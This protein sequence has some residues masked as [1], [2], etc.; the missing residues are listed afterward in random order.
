MTLYSAEGRTLPLKEPPSDAFET[1]SGMFSL[2]LVVREHWFQKNRGK[3]LRVEGILQFALCDKARY[4]AVHLRRDRVGVPCVRLCTANARSF[5]C[6]S[7]F[8]PWTSYVEAD[9]TARSTRGIVY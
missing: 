4:L 8:P 5:F 7:A 9:L 1:D 3:A 2:R 6:S